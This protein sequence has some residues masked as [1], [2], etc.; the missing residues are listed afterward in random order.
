MPCRPHSHVLPA[1]LRGSAPLPRPSCFSSS[2]SPCFSSSS[3]PPAIDETSIDSSK[4][5]LFVSVRRRARQEPWCE[6][7]CSWNST[8]F[9]GRGA[10]KK[11]KKKKKKR[12]VGKFWPRLTSESMDMKTIRTRAKFSSQPLQTNSTFLSDSREQNATFNR[13]SPFL[14]QTYQKKSQNSW[15]SVTSRPKERWTL[16][17]RSKML[18]ICI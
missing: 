13:F 16:N 11:K 4:S 17:L 10:P 1:E 12:T 2:S 8:R 7:V 3:P 6:T 14:A 18:R 9:P 15:T 5:R